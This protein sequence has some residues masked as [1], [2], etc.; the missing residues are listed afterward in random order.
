MNARQRFVETV[1]FG[2]PD[3]VPLVPGNAREST[4]R[5][6]RSQGL[7]E[8]IRSEGVIPYAYSQAGGTYPWA[9]QGESFPVNERM[10]PQFEEKVIEE[11]ER[12]RIVQ[13]WKGNVCEIGKQYSVE[14]LR[15]AVDFVTRR[16]IRC[17]VESRQDWEQMKERYDPEDAARLPGKPGE[18]G[19][20]LKD[21]SWFIELMFSGPFW[22]MREWL[23]FERLCTLFYDDPEM[24]R[25][26]VAFWQQYIGRLLSRV[27]E[28]FTPDSVHLSEDMAYKSH[29]MI[30]PEM[31]REFLLPCY[32]H[33]GELIREAGCPIYAMDSDGYIAELIPLWL[34]AGINA[35]DP[36]E[37]AAG[38]DIV[39]YREMFGRKMAYRGGVDKRAMAKG[40]DTLKAEID[41][42]RSVIEDG[43]YIPGCDHGVPGDV[44]WQN[45]VETV[46]LLAEATG[47]L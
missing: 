15:N 9:E 4:L 41:R 37:V 22:Q 26:M 45:Y 7:P 47:W 14:Y 46:R 10:V 28:Y 38:N 31:A 32:V 17:P 19:E 5:T 1:L 36:M 13:D 12:S 44:S 29:A 24:I 27:F 42:V 25:D 18:L 34:E 39:R 2:K 33:W 43:G 23:G 3:R 35:C 40:G 8:S 6:W 20:R 21:R 30:S 11:R 16:W